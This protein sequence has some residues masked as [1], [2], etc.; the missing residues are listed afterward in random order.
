ML[1]SHGYRLLTSIWDCRTVF[2][3]RGEVVLVFNGLWTCLRVVKTAWEKNQAWQY[4]NECCVSLCEQNHLFIL[5]SVDY[6]STEGLFV[7][8]S[9]CDLHFVSVCLTDG[10]LCGFWRLFCSYSLTTFLHHC[11]ANTL[12]VRCVFVW[13]RNC[14]GFE[15][16]IPQKW[17]KNVPV[18]LTHG[19]FNSLLVCLTLLY[20]ISLY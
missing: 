1:L 2:M 11:L 12:S 10:P 14:S 9:W 16:I 7:Y 18:F 15:A 4:R 3:W 19:A 20:Y 6:Q 8:V 13:F 17:Q 5:I